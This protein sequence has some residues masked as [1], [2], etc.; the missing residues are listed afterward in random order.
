MEANKSNRK[1][2]SSDTASTQLEFQDFQG[3]LL[4]FKDFPG[5]DFAE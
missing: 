3:P 2:V 5:L 4:T 1:Y